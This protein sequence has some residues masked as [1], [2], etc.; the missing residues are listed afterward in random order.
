MRAVLASPERVA[1]LVQIGSE[2]GVF[3]DEETVGFSEWVSQ[4]QTTPL[5]GEVRFGVAKMLFGASTV[6]Q[7]WWSEWERADRSKITFPADALINRDDITNA[8]VDI[9]CPSL[10]IHGTA[11][12]G[13]TCGKRKTPCSDRIGLFMNYKS[14]ESKEPLRRSFLHKGTSLFLLLGAV[15]PSIITS[16]EASAKQSET[17]ACDAPTPPA[18]TG[19]FFT[20]RSPERTSLVEKGIKGDRMTLTGRV[21]GTDCKPIRGALLDFWQTDGL[22]NYDNRG[23]KLRG[24]QFTDENGAFSLE[25]VVPGEYPGRTPHLHVRV[26]RSGGALLTTQLYFPGHPKNGPDFL[27]DERLVMKYVAPEFRFDFVI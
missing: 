7:H 3:T 8:L 1:A 9:S 11:D 19:P 21:I 5:N 2:S 4:S 24:H 27:F 12:E 15:G 6:A 10:V 20:P 16:R 14:N 18:M 23:Y 17:P 22:G 25:T 13:S 26:R